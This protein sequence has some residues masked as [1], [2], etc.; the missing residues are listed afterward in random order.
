MSCQLAQYIIPAPRGMHEPRKRSSST[1]RYS[2]L[3]A[4]RLARRRVVAPAY[5]TRLVLISASFAPLRRL[6]HDSKAVTTH[7]MP[8]SANAA[9]PRQY[10]PRDSA[11][12][13]SRMCW[14]PSPDRIATRPDTGAKI[15]A[16]TP[17][18]NEQ[19]RHHIVM[20]APDW[21]FS[22]NRPQVVNGRLR[23]P[24]PL[25]NMH[26]RKP[27]VNPPFRLDARERDVYVMRS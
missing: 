22:V 21:Q 6:P 19:N 15:R 27:H 9:A 1:A 26:M 20:L 25:S 18:G 7:G 4:R 8:G 3:A 14:R 5:R 23:H 13:L 10:P 24:R 11:H 17:A 2:L 12:M 16:M